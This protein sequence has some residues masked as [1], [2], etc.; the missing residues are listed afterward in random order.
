MIELRG[1]TKRFDRVLAVDNLSFTVPDGIIFGL[2]GPNGAG[3][4]TTIRMIMDI[5]RPDDG[6][7]LINGVRVSRDIYR[8]V[9]YLPEERGLYQKVRLGEMLSYFAALKG[10]SKS[11]IRKRVS[12]WLERFELGN[13]V[14]RKVEELSK[15]NQQKVQFI[16]SVIHDPDILILDEPFSGL[17]PLNQALVKDIIKERIVSGKTIVL[18]THQME[19]VERLCDEICLIDKGKS[20]LKGNLAELKKKYGNDILTVEYEEME[21]EPKTFRT[22][23]G[24]EITDCKLKGR[25]RKDRKVREALEEL[26]GL[27]VIKY[28]KVEEPSLEQ[29]FI[30]VV[31]GQV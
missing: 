9:G 26:S 12:Y 2:L 7:I 21:A 20:V 3:K 18:S 17:D 4:T 5:I 19:Q 13:F 24:V 14:G 15:G 11:E 6:E 1:V 30:D 10:V 22:L 8:R 28:F 27:G 29:I 16:I 23:E 31:R 25:L